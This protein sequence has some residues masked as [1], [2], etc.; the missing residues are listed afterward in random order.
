MLDVVYYPVSA[1][2]WFW[3]RAFSTILDPAGGAAWTLSVAFL[4]FTLRAILLKPALAQLRS[5]RILHCLKPQLAE[6]ARRH[7]GDRAALTTA[8]RQL[9]RQ[10]GVSPLAGCLPAIGQGLVLLGLY[11][12]L[13]SFNRTG[14]PLW[15]SAADN[16]ATPNYVFS[17][18]EVGSFLHAKLAGAPLAG[19]ITSTA[20]QL[21]AYTGGVSTT[22][23]VFVAVPLMVLAAIATHFTARAALAR[24]SAGDNASTGV[25]RALTLWAF[26]A[27]VL[28]G[29]SF[30]PV[31]V[32]IY[33][34]SN[35]VWTLA[36][37]HYAQ[38]QSADPE[39]V[40]TDPI[41]PRPA[42]PAPKTGSVPAISHRQRS[43]RRRRRR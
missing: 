19:S 5:Q 36:Q 12:V 16:A 34:L 24:Q 3:H 23:I 8:T 28:I 38:R 6:L 14:A 4:V 26:P 33:W 29:G 22:A 1:I 13:R 37:Q 18:D 17:A 11:H 35:N 42:A 40:S 31:A 39:A 9:N 20:Q 7:A 27:G 15:L 10:H 32:L 25:M 41:T 30:L 43:R 2:L 21:A